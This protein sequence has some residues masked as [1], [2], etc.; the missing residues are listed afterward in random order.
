MPIDATI[1]LDSGC[2][3][4]VEVVYGA[5][6]PEVG[7]YKCEDLLSDIRVYVDGVE[8]ESSK[9][10]KLGSGNCK[11]DVRHRNAD[12]SFKK[13]G[14]EVSPTFH[15]RLVHLKRDLYGDVKDVSVDVTKYDFIIRFESGYFRDS[16]VKNRCFKEHKKQSDGSYQHTKDCEKK[17]I[18]PVAHNIAVHFRLEDGEALELVKGEQTLLSS[19]GFDI[20]SSLVIEVI[21][22]NSTA[23]KFYRHYLQERDSYWLPNQG[24]P[25]P[26]CPVDPCPPFGG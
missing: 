17:T 3:L 12:G 7:Y 6:Y 18:R 1:I 26:L 11:I 21:A 20:K 13:K 24:D 4:P 9:P 15:D 16:M 5:Y 8:K 2:F 14:A 25:P 10:N 19:R 22:D 23:E